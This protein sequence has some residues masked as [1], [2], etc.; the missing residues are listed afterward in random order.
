MASC[1][2]HSNSSNVWSGNSSLV[3]SSIVRDYIRLLSRIR[4]RRSASPDLPLRNGATIVIAHSKFSFYSPTGR[5]LC[6]CAPGLWD[7]LPFH[8]SLSMEASHVFSPD[9]ILELPIE[10][11]PLMLVKLRYWYWLLAIRCGSGPPAGK[12]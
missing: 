7:C 4:W 5:G 2:T 1:L 11:A 6:S 3:L 12:R 10:S 9:F 8:S